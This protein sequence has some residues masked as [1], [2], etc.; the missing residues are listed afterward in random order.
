MKGGI[1]EEE[2]KKVILEMVKDQ[3]QLVSNRMTALE[4]ENQNIPKGS[5]EKIEFFETKVQELKRK[6]SIYMRDM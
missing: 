2:L 3:I 1:Q 4:K 5:S 6:S